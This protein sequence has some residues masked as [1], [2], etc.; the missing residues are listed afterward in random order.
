MEVKCKNCTQPFKIEKID[1]DFYAKM[2]VPPPSFC[3]N[4]RQQR[5]TSHGNHLHLYK[6]KCDFSGKEIVSNHPPDS[7]Y[8]VYEID[9]WHSNNWDPF[10]YGSDYDFNK[11]FFEQFAD[12]LKKVPYPAVHRGYQYDENSDYTNYAGKN[13]N[14]Y[15]IFD[16]DEDWDCYYCYGTNSSKD[17]MDCYRIR[18]CELCYECIDVIDCYNCQ[19]SQDCSN[20][21]DSLFLKNCIGCKNCIACSNLKNKEYFINNKK[22]SKEE[23]EKYREKMKDPEFLE[24]VKDYFE[25]FKLQFPQKFMHGVQNENSTGDYLTNCKN[26]TECYESPDLWDCK[27][28]YQ[29][30]MPLKDSMDIQECGEGE[31]LYESAFSGYDTYNLKFCVH[32]FSNA[33][34][35]QYCNFCH[36]SRNCFGCASLL[37][38]EYCI[39][40]KQYTKEEYE[41]LLPRIIEHMKSTGEYGEFFPMNLSLFPYNLTVAQTHFPL[42]KEQALEKGLRWQ[43]K[44]VETSDQSLSDRSL[45]CEG[46]DRHYLIIKQEA[47]LLE[48]FGISVPKFCFYCRNKKRHEKRNLRK[49]YDSN[50]DKC[51]VTFKTTYAPESPEKVYCEKCYAESLT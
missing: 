51:A 12:L 23:F 22:A 30:F 6:R 33:S 40:N 19:F 31:Q 10:Q 17:C 46:C 42:T 1:E 38:H 43:E 4:C 41:E 14:C 29:A 25:K 32:C 34:D 47:Q 36:H 15:L 20:C 27:Y 2:Q 35:L 18:S 5:R 26:A 3:P 37:R 28:V 7:L 9:I 48:R 21:S 16:S 44:N 50:C 11:P 13:K 45:K 39:L 24:Q 49:I 8:K